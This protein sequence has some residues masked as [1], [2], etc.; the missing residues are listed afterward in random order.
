MFINH[1]KERL[2]RGELA[3]GIGLRQART[4]DIAMIAKACN[5]DWL[6]ID[7][8]H[9]S[10]SIDTAAQI[11][12]AALAAGITP[13]VRVP[14]HQPFQSSR[15]LDGGAMGVVVP[16]VDTAEQARSIVRACKYPPIGHRSVAG[17]APQLGFAPVPIGEATRAMND[18]MLIVVMLETPEA[19]ENA[20]EIAA[21]EGV[22]VLLI[23]SNDL[24][25][26]MGIPG[27]FDHPKLV[28]GYRRTIEA[29]RRHG[30]WPGMGGV[31]D[32]KLM[33][34]FIGM[35][36]RFILSGADLGFMMSA[37]TSRTSFLRSLDSKSAG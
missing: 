5:F 12:V 20:D 15:V 7:M 27:Q 29:T 30:K 4:A 28:D 24:C 37:A 9:N 25:A 22:D 3:L 32:E 13:L 14:D 16:H 36:A 11:S 17:A 19:I 33:R 21:V 6:F 34:Q 23:G 26:E 2:Q 10:M 35:G 1:A 31:Y 8:E 18:S